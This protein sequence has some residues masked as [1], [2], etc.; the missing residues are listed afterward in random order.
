MRNRVNLAQDTFGQ[1]DG[2]IKEM[3]NLSRQAFDQGTA[4]MI[5]AKVMDMAKQGII[6]NDQM[7]VVAN[8]E[9]SKINNEAQ[10]KKIELERDLQ[11]QYS[12][13]LKEKQSV[14]DGIMQDQS[15]NENEKMNYATQITAAYNAVS[16]NYINTMNNI[17]NTYSQGTQNILSPFSAVEA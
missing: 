2:R 14:L 7:D 12:D 9:L 4:N 6:G 16:N 17:S 8:I 15:M 1:I 5:R 3:E 13:L 10:L 11:A